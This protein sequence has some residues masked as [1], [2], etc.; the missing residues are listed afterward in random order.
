MEPLKV[1]KRKA[2]QSK[3]E[4]PSLIS[5]FLKCRDLVNE[6]EQIDFL[7][8]S[9]KNLRSPFT[10]F[11]M[12]K[13]CDR[14][15]KAL[16]NDEQ[17]G[18]YC[19]YDLDGSSGAAILVEGFKS[20]GF[21]E[22]KLYQPRRLT[23]GYGF[24]KAGVDYFKS[25]GVSVI[26]TVDVAITA[27]KTAL[28]SKENGIDLIITDHHLADETLPEALAVINP[29][30]KECDAGLGHLC[31][32]G[33]GFYLIYGLAKVI[34]EKTGNLPEDFKIDDLL[35]FL[36]I[37]TL[38][39]MVPLIDENRALVKQG[40]IKFSSTPRAGLRALKASLDLLGKTIDSND[41]GFK[42]APKLNALSRLDT[43]LRPTGLLLE[44]DREKAEVIVTE[45]L[46][47]NQKRV[48][49]LE[50]GLN[51]ARKHFDETPP[52]DLVYYTSKSIHPGVMGLIATRLVEVFGVPA[53]IGSELDNG[54]VVGSARLPNGIGLSLKTVMGECPSLIQFGGHAEAAGFELKLEDTFD[55]YKELKSY[56]KSIDLDEVALIP[57][58][59][60]EALLDEMDKEFLVWLKR[61]EPFGVGFNRPSFKLSRIKVRSLRKLKEKHW[62][63]EIEDHKGNASSVL[64]FSPSKNHDVNTVFNEG[65]EKEF[66]YNFYVEPQVNFYRKVES[67]QLLLKDVEVS[68]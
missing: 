19:D 26:V 16:E 48:E 68:F 67:L 11:G 20:L 65:R 38:T 28:Y 10:L 13:A 57:E 36:V 24:H 47:V 30:I 45:A 40:L 39:D 53:F 41:I 8:P 37:G 29:N 63:I 34:K 22:P 46:N 32:A 14:L 55:F 2:L 5:R 66:N 51:E 31:G 9:L 44:T 59:D 27:H 4:I 6:E 52:E 62:K 21:K 33:V 15:F 23:E 49:F 64:W 60:C 43:D 18:V 58:Y 12:S 1:R 56:L 3:Y 50:N 61:M 25:E 42:L 54:L 7:T 35:D 17:I